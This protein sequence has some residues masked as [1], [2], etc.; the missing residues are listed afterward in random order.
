MARVASR[1]HAEAMTSGPL[2]PAGSSRD[3]LGTTLFILCA[4]LAA[5]MLF[6]G[7]RGYLGPESAAR[8]FGIPLADLADA[9]FVRIKAGRDFSI[10]VILV[11]LLV[12]RQR[13]ALTAM[14]AASMIMPLN[15]CAL[16]IA[17]APGRVGY[18]L[19]V[20]GSAVVYG[21]VVAWLLWRRG[22]LLRERAL[23]P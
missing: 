19:A 15:D 11:A 23:R 8:G 14:I 10:G 17:S 22:R 12:M 21:A 18:A 13:A 1:V 3:E 4:V 6:L 20:H 5:F 9:A 7:V 16:V 2:A